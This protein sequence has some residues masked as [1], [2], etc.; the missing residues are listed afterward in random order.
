MLAFL[1]ENALFLVLLLLLFVLAEILLLLL[2][3]LVLL[4][5]CDHFEAV[6]HLLF[7]LL[8]QV[9]DSVDVDGLFLEVPVLPIEGRLGFGLLVSILRLVAERAQM[10]DRDQLVEGLVVH[11]EDLLIG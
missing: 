9:D 4:E 8:L 6:L 10:L 1:A 7:V 3:E 2:F 5:L 11:Q